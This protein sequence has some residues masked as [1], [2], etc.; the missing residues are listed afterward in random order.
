[1]RNNLYLQS[2]QHEKNFILSKTR[3]NGFNRKHVASRID[4]D[5][6]LQTKYK[7]VS[8]MKNELFTTF[9][10]NLLYDKDEDK[11]LMKPYFK[12]PLVDPRSY[13]AHPTFHMH[14]SHHT[15]QT[16]PLRSFIWPYD[17]PNVFMLDVD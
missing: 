8:K 2:L 9:T 7:L 6:L 12:R 11:E 14:N 4:K 15:L 17:F 5:G 16:P 10:V 1:M 3:L 13:L